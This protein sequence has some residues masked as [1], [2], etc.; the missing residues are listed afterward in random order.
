MIRPGSPNPLTEAL[1][2]QLRGAEY[3]QA[4]RLYRSIDELGEAAAPLQ[5]ELGRADRYYLLVSIL[6]RADAMHPWLYARCREVEAAPDGHLDL[7]A[8]GHYKSTHIT[9]GGAIQEIINDPEITIGFESNDRLKALYPEVLWSRPAN[10]SQQ[11]SEDGGI[12]V[13]RKGNPK[14]ATIEAWG[15]VDG[16]PTSK[17]FGLRIYDDVVTRESVST[18]EQVQKTTEA[19]ELSQNLGSKDG[20]SWHIGTRY[21]FAD[22]YQTM[23]DRKAL[24]P[25]IYPATD[26]GTLDGK[27]VFLDEAAWADLKTTTSD[28]TIA[29]QQLQNPLSGVQ[30]TFDVLWLKRYEVRP[31]TL[32]VYVMCDPASSHKQD[33]DYTAMA[34]IGVDYDRNKYLLDGVRQKLDLKGRWTAVS[35]LRRRWLNEIG[36]QSVYVGYERY[37]MQSDLEYFEERMEIEGIA[38]PIRELAWPRE[39]PGSKDDRIQRLLPD[40]K[41]GRF[42]LP[43]KVDAETSAQRRVREQG[44]PYRI[45]KPIRRKDQNGNLYDLSVIFTEEFRLHPFGSHEDLLDAASRI[46]DMD[47]AP[48]VIIDERA[49]EPEWVE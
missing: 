19:W 40:T 4:L 23:L 39:G 44:E 34:V 24:V 5:A 17:H 31:R 6:G 46:Y 18:P 3:A 11:W 41:T 32:N 45:A 14:E 21:S 10:E 42:Y 48:P 16:Q 35:A 15:L 2:E 1:L 43:A 36:V 49:L 29:C 47:Y 28:A 9:Y 38:F 22:S 7:W 27:P 12:T 25:R 13:R 30:A 37:G 26:D 8:R 20:R 33:S